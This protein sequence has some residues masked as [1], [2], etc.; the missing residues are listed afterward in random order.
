MAGSLDCF[1]CASAPPFL[2]SLDEVPAGVKGGECIAD[3][4]DDPI[5]ER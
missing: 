3:A 2:S 5:E 4:G 1:L